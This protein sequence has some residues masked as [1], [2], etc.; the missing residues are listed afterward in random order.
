MLALVGILYAAKAAYVLAAARFGD[1]RILTSALLYLVCDL[2]DAAVIWLWR[3]EPLLMTVARAWTGA[4]VV[5]MLV[6]LVTS[7]VVRRALGATVFA[8][9]VAVSAAVAAGAAPGVVDR[10]DLWGFETVHGVVVL[11][12]LAFAA[13][14]VAGGRIEPPTLILGVLACAAAP[15]VLLGGPP[16]G[17]LVEYIAL[18][19]LELFG[20]AVAVGCLVVWRGRHRAPG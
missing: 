14:R 13:V 15:Q 2:A 5:A 10:L 19:T 17:S 6:V 3:P 1:R 18:Q 9:P 16:R 4:G 7:P 11:G 8:F 12:G 20:I